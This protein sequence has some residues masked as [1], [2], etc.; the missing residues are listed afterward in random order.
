MALTQA[1]YNGNMNA[2]R[3]MERYGLS[4]CQQG[5]CTYYVKLMEQECLLGDQQA[6]ATADAMHRHALEGW[7]RR[8]GR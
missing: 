7:E 2:C 3:Q 4:W 5:D 8:W 1:C 6:C